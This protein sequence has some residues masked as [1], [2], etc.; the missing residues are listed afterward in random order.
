MVHAVGASTQTY[1]VYVLKALK[2]NSVETGML[3]PTIRLYY[4]NKGEVNCSRHV[5][6]EK[7]CK[8][9]GIFQK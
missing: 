8:K 5:W 9:L 7:L 1:N 2:E 6:N 4:L 3:E